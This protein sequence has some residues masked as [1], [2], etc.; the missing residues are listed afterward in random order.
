MAGLSTIF[1]TRTLLPALYQRRPAKAALRNTFFKTVRT[2]D[3]ES[4]DIDIV[5]NKQRGAAF[6]TLRQEGQVVEREAYE[7]RTYKPMVLKPKIPTT[8]ADAFK[9]Q[10]GEIIYAGNMTPADRAGEIIAG[11]L[12]TLE[13]MISRTEEVMASQALVSDAIKIYDA[14]KN[15]I[16]ADISFDRAADHTLSTGTVT[17]SYGG[18]WTDSSADPME[19]LRLMQRK[20]AKDSGLLADV[21]FAGASAVDAFISHPSVRDVGKMYNQQLE[22]ISMRFPN[23]MADGLRLVGVFE[24]IT[25]FEYLETYLDPADGTTVTPMIPDK[26]I[27]MGS[28]DARSEMLYGAIPHLNS[29]AAVSRFPYSYTEDDPPVR[30]L[31]LYSRPLPS[32]HQV[33]GFMVAAV[34]S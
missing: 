24:G 18:L 13:D 31:Q 2:F 20:I 23:F 16:S 11:D 1:E 12:I 32:P 5:K 22:Q 27:L 10:P 21:V 3:T 4:V 14:E 30:W 26:S 29:L 8:A 17:S 34:M 28:T 33:D 6:V 25:V 7:A 19:T 9:R 15:K